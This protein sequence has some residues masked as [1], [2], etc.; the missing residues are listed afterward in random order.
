MKIR[1]GARR[2]FLLLGL[3]LVA[4]IVVACAFAA[5]QLNRASDSL[6]EAARSVRRG[7]VAAAEAAVATAADAAGSAR[8]FSQHPGFALLGW[9]PGLS[10]DVQ[11]VRDLIEVSRRGTALATSAVDQLTGLGTSKNG[12][13]DEGFAQLFYENGQIDLDAID[14]IAGAAQAA[15][16]VTE[17][18]RALLADDL[19]VT[20]GSVRRGVERA[21]ARLDEIDELSNQAATMARLI[22]SFVGR[23]EPRTYLLAFQSPSEARGG[24]GLI[25]VYGLLSADRGRISLG[26]VGPIE[27]LGPRVGAPVEPPNRAFGNTYGPLSSLNDWRQSNLSPNFP[28]TSEVLLELF[29]RVRGERLDGVV[30]MDPIA[31]GELTRGTGPISVPGWD[32]EIT[33]NSARRLLLF[34]IYRRFVY[35]ER[36]QN[37]YLRALVDEL[38]ARVEMGDVDAVGLVQGFRAAA[39]KQHLKIYSSDA[40]EQDLLTELRL[41]ADPRT[42]T[43]P[44]QIAYTNNNSGNKLDF[45][46]RR[47]QDVSIDLRPSGTAA[48]STTIELTNDVPKRGLR[49]IARAGVRTGLA[50]GHS[51]MSI[52]VLLPGG[53]RRPRFSIDGD[54]SEHF[55]GRDSGAPMVWDILELAPEDTTTVTVTYRL[56]DAIAPDGTFRFTLWPQATARPDAYSLEVSPPGGFVLRTRSRSTARL[57]RSGRLKEPVT[58][59]AVLEETG[60]S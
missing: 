2:I 55:A 24:G 7:D 46:L 9:A 16:E 50:M 54:R 13:P 38:W 5:I 36:K 19:D 28:D 43:G 32:K 57:T 45:F 35:K 26:E 18:S 41:T 30:A 10:R 4:D 39:D 29:E 22:P 31:L 60:R 1:L 21:R 20:F 14:V 15:S 11:A 52:H 53:A 47:T 34:E 40:T 49:A 33:G 3:L 58:L 17:G 42:V 48:V 27:A 23:D 12:D 44:V 51:R 56:P 8:W 6:A 59:E 25:G 37:V